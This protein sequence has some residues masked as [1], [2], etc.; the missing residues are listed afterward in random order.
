[1]K[2]IGA[3]TLLTLWLCLALTACSLQAIHRYEYQD[4]ELLV[5]VSADVVEYQ[6]Q[7]Y[8]YVLDKNSWSITYPNGAYD[9]ET[10]RDDGN[11]VVSSSWN[12]SN[13]PESQ[14]YLDSQTLLSYIRTAEGGGAFYLRPLWWVGLVAFGVGVLTMLWPDWLRLS[15]QTFRIIARGAGALVAFGGLGLM[16]Y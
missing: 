7:T 15:K 6:G 4:Q 5:D 16:F 13:T 12:Y 14:G 9:Q 2:R 10:V 11:R 3:L 1:M 8:T